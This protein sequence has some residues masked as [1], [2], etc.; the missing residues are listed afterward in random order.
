MDNYNIFDIFSHYL[1]DN[2][3]YHSISSSILL[4][5]QCKNIIQDNKLYL[6]KKHA[7]LLKKT[8]LNLKSSICIIIQFFKYK[9]NYRY[10]LNSIFNI[11]CYDK[12]IH[13]IRDYN[14]YKNDKLNPLKNMKTFT[15]Q[16]YNERIKTSI[17]FSLAFNNAD[18]PDYTNKYKAIHDYY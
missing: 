6:R 17:N 4:S 18:K 15:Y 16:T 3:L 10:L 2:N 9:S 7:Y 5:K 8:I 14:D 12:Y 11:Y 1:I 13:H